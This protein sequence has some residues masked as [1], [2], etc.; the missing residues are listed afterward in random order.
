MSLRTL[1][2]LLAIML[3]A[4][5]AVAMMASIINIEKWAWRSSEQQQAKLLVGLLSDELKM[6]MIVDSS[7]EVDQLVKMFISHV[8]GMT[9]YLR[10]ENGPTEKFGDSAIP[11][12][13]AALSGLSGEVMPVIGQDQWYA[14]AINLHRTTLGSIA[15][16]FPS[17]SW[18]EID[19]KIRTRLMLTALAIALLAALLVYVTSGRVVRQLSLFTRASNRVGRGDFSVHLPARS[20]NEFGRL[21]NQF[22]RMVSGLEHREKV[23]DLYGCYQYPQQVADE[24]DRKTHRGSII[25]KRDVSILVMD[26]VDFN[27]YQKENGK[28]DYITVL[29]RFFSLFQHI[30]HEFGGHVDHFT[31]DTMVAVFNHPFDLKRHE[32]RAAKAGLTII[33]G[34]RKMAVVRDDGTLIAFRTGMVIGEVTAGY[35]GM[36]R[37]KGLTVVGAPISLAARMAK[38]S[39]GNSL[40]APCGTML[41]LGHGF[42]QEEREEVSM[43]GGESARCI[44][45]LSGEQYIDQEIDGVLERSFSRI[46]IG[47]SD[48]DDVW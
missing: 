6:P 40:V 30:I 2:S 27:G 11:S 5:V 41:L 17:Q 22:N 8:P 26:M 34:C 1:W 24:F 37:R 48:E 25:M 20:E 3:V 9:V 21:A 36:S 44:H 4:L 10:W 43:P 33:T 42:K 39:D 18:R 16:F 46:E 38:L 31:G 14:M 7:T 19:Q 13:V 15:V 35:L 32:N 12:G 45:I 28:E 29:N 47:D 23:H